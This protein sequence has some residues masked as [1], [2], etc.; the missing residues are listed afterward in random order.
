MADDQ[1]TGAPAGDPWFKTAGADDVI[2][3]H[4]QN[5]GWDKL[6]PAKAAIAAATSHK[7]AER[8]MG[9]PS[10]LLLRLPK[11]AADEAGWNNVYTKLGAPADAKVYDDTVNGVKFADNTDLAPAYKSAIGELSRKFHLSADNSKL[12]AQT[13]VKVIEADI[14]SD[15]AAEKAQVE[16]Q[17]A[18]LRKAWGTGFDANMVIAQ[19]AASKL[20]LTEDEFG[21]MV[22]LI[23]ANK[24]LTA[25][26]KI[27]TKVGEDTFLQTAMGNKAQ[28]LTKEQAAERLDQ[29][30]GDKEWAKRLTS[31]DAETAREFNNL[32]KIIVGFA[33]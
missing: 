26:H 28:T 14:Q 2:V 31:G 10:E 23:G 8:L 15:A 3:G 4:M 9:V 7:E 1:N 6:D 16:E 29:L 19:N 25:L 33:A 18:E 11:D 13:F 32:N 24:V 5:R 27:G 30:K 22:D 12:L 21:A 17:T 20:G